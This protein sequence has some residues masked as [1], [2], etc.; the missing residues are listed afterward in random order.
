MWKKVL[1]AIFLA[2]VIGMSTGCLANRVERY[3]YQRDVM[4]KPA[5]IV[6]ERDSRALCR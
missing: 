5:V 2:S 6:V 1:S 3:L 4:Q